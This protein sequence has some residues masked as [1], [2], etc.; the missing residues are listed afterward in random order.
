MQYRRESKGPQPHS[1]VFLGG[2]FPKFYRCFGYKQFCNKTTNLMKEDPLQLS[3]LAG[4][5][6]NAK[7]VRMRLITILYRHHHHYHH[8]H[9]HHNHHHHHHLC[10]GLDEEVMQKRSI[11]IGGLR[12]TKANRSTL[13]A[14][15]TTLI[16]ESKHE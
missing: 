12:K 9:H 11:T 15:S 10:L 3:I 6:N 13:T 8:H 14:H 7:E 4:N 2:N 16:I 1:V 5:N